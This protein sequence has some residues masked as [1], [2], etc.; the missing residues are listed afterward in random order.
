[1][2]LSVHGFLMLNGQARRKWHITLLGREW[3][4]IPSHVS[5]FSVDWVQKALNMGTIREVVDKASGV[6]SA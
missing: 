5:A 2:D 1:M 4:I 6:R 3:R